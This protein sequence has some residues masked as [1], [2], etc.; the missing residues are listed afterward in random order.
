MI[1]RFSAS[2][3]IL[4]TLLTALTFF[5]ACEKSNPSNPAHGGQ[6]PTRY[7]TI[8]DTA[9]IPSVL[10]IA[11]GNSI[12]FLN[13]SA[14]VKSVVSDDSTTILTGPIAPGASFFYKKDTTGTFGYRCL[15]DP[16]LRGT[17]I[18]NP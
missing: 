3:G 8:R 15:E 7:V 4:C 16:L 17:I 9:I 10:T 2:K 18:I 6:L 1:T 11:V 14:S 13:Q 12:T 5:T